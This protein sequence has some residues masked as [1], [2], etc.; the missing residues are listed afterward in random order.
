MAS[1]LGTE[2]C[3]TR[4]E[5]A[6]RGQDDGVCVAAGQEL[7][8]RFEGC[9]AGPRRSRGQSLGVNITDGDELR[10]LAVPFDRVDMV[11]RDPPAADE[12]EPDPSSGDQWSVW[13]ESVGQ[14][15]KVWTALNLHG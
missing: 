4:M 8:D 2:N 1:G 14:V 13:E 11:P 3:L 12:G 7:F 10:A 15:G 9:R 5:S 6:G